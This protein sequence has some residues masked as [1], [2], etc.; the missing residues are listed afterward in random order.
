MG[1]EKKVFVKGTPEREEFTA[2]GTIT[3][4]QLLEIDSSDNV[5]VH[6]SAGQNVYS[7]FALENDIEGDD[8]DDDYASGEQVQCAWAS[9][10]HIVN[11]L[12]KDGENIAIGDWLESDGTG[13]LAEHAADDSTS[14][15]YTNQIVGIA[16]EA[17]DLS[18]S[19][20]ADPSSRRCLVQII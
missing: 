13:D 12:I 15:N 5:I 17:L 14:T 10:G 18:D 16:R 11:A 4:G 9:P 20:G 1:A 6:N 19:S 7:L 3:P 2:G 8:I